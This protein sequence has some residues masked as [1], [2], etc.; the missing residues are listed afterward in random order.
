MKEQYNKEKFMRRRFIVDRVPLCLSFGT[1]YSSWHSV[2][3]GPKSMFFPYRERMFFKPIKINTSNYSIY[4]LLLTFLVFFTER[5][6]YVEIMS[7]LFS[8]LV[9]S[10]QTG[11]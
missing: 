1:K 11:G 6:L 8:G 7:E 9:I 3:E 5:T 10:A 4:F 2:F